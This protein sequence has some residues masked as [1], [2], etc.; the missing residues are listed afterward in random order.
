MPALA[1]GDLV[2]IGLGFFLILWLYAAQVTLKGLGNALADHV[3]L[4]GG[5]IRSALNAIVDYALS[6][7]RDWIRPHLTPLYRWLID[8]ADAVVDFPHEAVRFGRALV[9][10]LDHYAH[11][12]VH[13]VI[14]AFVNPIIRRVAA[15]EAAL[16]TIPRDIARLDRKIE[17]G[18]DNLRD[19]VLETILTRALQGIDRLRHDVFSEALPALRDF[20]MDRVKDLR[21]EVATVER[22]IENV[23]A[24]LREL[25]KRLDIPLEV[26]E[27]LVAAIGITAA[28]EAVE[29]LG[30]CR[31]KLKTLCTSD[32]F[33]WEQFIAGLALLALWPGLEELTRET[34]SILEGVAQPLGDFIIHGG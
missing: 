30:T 27:A 17:H 12:V 24:D 31:G 19:W 9:S 29:T 23:G 25:A 4:I 7:V 20:V 21:G 26:I 14:K 10:K 22:G 8:L 3:P 15:A 5:R 1:A 16:E 28:I 11:V 13:D 33:A 34:G 18:I 2:I 32:P 6:P